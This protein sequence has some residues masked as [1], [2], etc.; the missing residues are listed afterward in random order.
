MAGEFKLAEVN[1]AELTQAVR[2][3]YPLTSL[4]PMTGD[5]VEILAVLLAMDGEN[6]LTRFINVMSDFSRLLTVPQL[7]GAMQVAEKLA[8]GI[9]EVLSIGSKKALL[10]LH[11]TFTDRE[12]A[13]PLTSGYLLVPLTSESSIKGERLLVVGGRLR[14]GVDLAHS[15][16]VTAYPYMLLRIEVRAKREDWASFQNIWTPLQEAIKAL[17]KGERGREDA[18]AYVRTAISEALLAPDF[19]LYDR[20]SIARKVQ[21]FYEEAKKDLGQGA[22]SFVLASLDDVMSLVVPETEIPRDRLLTFREMFPRS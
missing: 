4:I 14:T 6:S 21:S 22:I 19:V 13:N 17:R 18:E 10:G 3:N 11:Q 15:E 7:S 12:G 8:G 5:T 2:L 20:N 16:A 1:A 9:N